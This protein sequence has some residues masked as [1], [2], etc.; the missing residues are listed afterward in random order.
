MCNL[1][2]IAFFV[3]CGPEDKEGVAAVLNGKASAELRLFSK[4]DCGKA[5]C[6]GGVDGDDV[7]GEVGKGGDPEGICDDINDVNVPTGD[8]VVGGGCC[9][10]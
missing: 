7:K 10:G 3:A 2:V 1:F 6:N 5:P 4:G 9:C 8:V